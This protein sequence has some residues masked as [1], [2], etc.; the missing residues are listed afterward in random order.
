MALNSCKHFVF[1]LYRSGGNTNVNRAISCRHI[2]AP[3]QTRLSNSRLFAG[4]SWA[5]ALGSGRS[6]RAQH[7][8]EA[9]CP[10]APCSRVTFAW[11][12][13]FGAQAPFVAAGQRL[14][15]AVGRVTAHS[16]ENGWGCFWGL[17][18]SRQV[19]CQGLC[20]RPQRCATSKPLRHC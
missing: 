18:Q 4:G 12:S 14:M 5:Q 7:W 8:H 19:V 20:L 10:Y 6:G 1:W 3:T 11:S 16:L 15:P 2:T 9:D 13:L 17:M